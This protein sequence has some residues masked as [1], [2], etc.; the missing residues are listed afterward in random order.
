MRR[1]GDDAAFLG[2]QATAAGANTPAQA[3]HL[4]AELAR[5]MDM[6]E[7]ENVALD[8]LAQL[9]PE[10][11][12]VHWQDTIEFLKIVTEAW[13]AHLAETGLLS[14]AA[15]RNQAILAEAERLAATPPQ[16]P[17]IVAGV[18]GSIPA[19]VELMRAVAG[20]PQGAIVLPGLDPHLDDESWE[21]IVPGHPVRPEDAARP[22]RAE[23]ERRAH[24]QRHRTGPGAGR[25]RRPRDR[26]D[27]PVGNDGALA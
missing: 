18:T 20:L 23:P 13:P 21:T 11:F 14:P 7:T 2:P 24:S 16:G 17:V 27:A 25:P 3:A 8:G 9:V 4:A 26:S 19:T 6:V 15:R 5:L 1:P 12:S 10:E 22:A